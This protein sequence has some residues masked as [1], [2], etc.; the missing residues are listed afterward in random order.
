MFGSENALRDLAVRQSVLG[1][2]VVTLPCGWLPP[3]LSFVQVPRVCGSRF[4]E[5]CHEVVTF[6]HEWLPPEVYER[7]CAR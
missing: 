5:L 4:A 2:R 3:D 1:H 6:A 7:G